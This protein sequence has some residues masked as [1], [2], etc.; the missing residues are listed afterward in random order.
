M[1]GSPNSTDLPNMVETP[2]AF[3]S[4]KTDVHT[5]YDKQPIHALTTVIRHQRQNTERQR[6]TT[7]SS[8][9]TQ[10]TKYYKKILNNRYNIVTKYTATFGGIY[11]QRLPTNSIF[12]FASIVCF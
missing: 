4:V 8:I 7:I 5:M 11:L 2:S 1:Y 6:K 12:Y 3:L 10:T 9:Q